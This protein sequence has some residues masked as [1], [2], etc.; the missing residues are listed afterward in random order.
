MGQTPTGGRRPLSSPNLLALDTVASFAYIDA[1][2]ADGSNLTVSLTVRVTDDEALR[3]K[4]LADQQERKL[5]DTIRQLIRRGLK[6][7]ER[8]K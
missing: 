1:M 3:I 8:A 5:A 6:A 4:R 2:K 7:L